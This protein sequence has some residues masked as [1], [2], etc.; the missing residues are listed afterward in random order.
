[1][2]VIPYHPALRLTLFTSLF[3]T[4]ANAG[5]SQNYEEDFYNAFHKGDT[6]LQITLLNQWEKSEL[7][8]PEMHIAWFNYYINKSKSDIITISDHSNA[9]E[10]LAISD[11]SGKTAGYLSS[12]IVYSD[13]YAGKAIERINS[14]ILQ[15]PDRLDMRFGKIYFL[16]KIENFDS[17]TSNIISALHHSASISHKWVWKHNEVM[18]NPEHTLLNAIQDYIVQLYNTDNDSLLGHMENISKTVLIY[19]P[20]HVESL[21]NLSVV[22]ILKGDY[23]KA[24]LP[25]LKAEKTAPTDAIIL[26]NIAH[27]YKNLGDKNKA[28]EYYKKVKKHG[29]AES[30]KYADE[31]IKLLK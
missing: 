11:S 9:D 25:L 21:S 16:G 1:M 5:I 23:Q 30:V 28:I 29:D 20:D 22:Y 3:L 6:A 10:Y 4:F 31:Q 14:A 17:F 24:L 13:Y 18:A 12:G 27:A 19:F 15:N 7:Q 2:N 26:N 8:N